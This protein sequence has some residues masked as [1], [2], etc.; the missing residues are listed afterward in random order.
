MEHPVVQNEVVGKASKH[1]F[2]PESMSQKHA[3]GFA[4]SLHAVMS[5]NGMTLKDRLIAVAIMIMVG[6][7]R[8][9]SH[10]LA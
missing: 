10:W 8:M 3:I 9:P 1:V 5:W 4:M 2:L 6:V 7:N